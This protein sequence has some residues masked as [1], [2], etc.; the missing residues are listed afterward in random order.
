M[1]AQPAPTTHRV[2]WGPP[3]DMAKLP[4]VDQ[5]MAGQKATAAKPPP[6]LG[7]SVM[8]ASALKTAMLLGTSVGTAKTDATAGDKPLTLKVFRIF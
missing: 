6:T 5:P 7:P 3:T 1:P 2:G 4:Y 8:L